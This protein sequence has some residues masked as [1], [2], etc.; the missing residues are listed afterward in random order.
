M[1]KQFER[2]SVRSD[3]RSTQQNNDQRPRFG[4]GHIGLGV[5]D[6]NASVDFYEK[7]GMRLVVNMGRAAILELRGG[8]HLIVQQNDG[9]PDSLDVIVDDIDDTHAVLSALGAE[10]SAIERG[11]P[12]DR[13]VATDPSGNVLVVNSNHAIGVV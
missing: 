5:R 11:S 13:F 10:P 9:P 6:V 2:T 7:A 1:F 12:H 3:D 4:I 8:T